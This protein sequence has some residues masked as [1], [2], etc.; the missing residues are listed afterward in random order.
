MELIDRIVNK[1]YEEFGYETESGYDIRSWSDDEITFCGGEED[2]SK[3]CDFICDEFD[4]VKDCEFY[5]EV[6]GGIVME[7]R[8]ELET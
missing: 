4:D 8:I 2:F 5:Y 7:T 1:L 6:D 3:I